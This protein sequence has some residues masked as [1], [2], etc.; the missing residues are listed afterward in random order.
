MIFFFYFGAVW[1]LFLLIDISIASSGLD[2]SGSIINNY[3][4]NITIEMP[5]FSKRIVSL[6]FSFRHTTLVEKSDD[7]FAKAL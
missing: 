5:Y 3:Y 1:F 6:N 4:N 7:L 2:S